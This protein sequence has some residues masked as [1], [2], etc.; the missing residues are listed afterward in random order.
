M[1]YLDNAS[2]TQVKVKAKAAINKHLDINY[3]NPMAV[4][5]FA[6]EPK[7]TIDNSRKII[8]N[9]LLC[10]PENIIF[11]SGGSEANNLAIKGVAFKHFSDTKSPGH[12]VTSEIEHH[13][14]LNACKQLE[15]MGIA[16]VTYI[17]P[18][19]DGRIYEN[20][21]H[22]AINTKDK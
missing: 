4:Y 9:L 10:E 5:N 7:E 15:K 1:I 11:T 8:S 19:K 14:I 21:I 2:T 22:E 6:A 3:A 17:K 12:I 13:S 16:T 20:M 18:T